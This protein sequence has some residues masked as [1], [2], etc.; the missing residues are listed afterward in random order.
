MKNENMILLA[1][2]AAGILILPKLIGKKIGG[3]TSTAPST[4]A[5]PWTYEVARD[6]GWVYYS[7]GTS[8]GPDGAYYKGSDV[9]YPAGGMYQ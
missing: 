7:D 2:V 6:S 4:A 8:I 1:M 9:V 3:S 5:N